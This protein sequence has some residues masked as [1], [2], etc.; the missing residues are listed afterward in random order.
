MKQNSSRG[1]EGGREGETYNVRVADC[2][3]GGR[4]FLELRPPA[5]CV[6]PLSVSAAN[7]EY[8]G[9]R[10]IGNWPS[11]ITPVTDT[12]SYYGVFLKRSSLKV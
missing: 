7:W 2:G 12:S 4:N 3:G 1:R 10:G 5:A 9:K 11:W 6:C 8:F